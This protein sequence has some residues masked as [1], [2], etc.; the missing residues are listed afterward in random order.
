MR[1]FAAASGLDDV[2]PEDHAFFTFIKKVVRHRFRQAGFRRFS[3]PVFEET[4]LYERSLGKEC[5]IFS[6]ELY[7]FIDRQGRS[8]SLRPEITTSLVRAFIQHELDKGPL[9]VEWYYI[10]HCFRYE[11]PTSRTKRQ[12]WQF[13]AEILGESD[14]AIDAQIIFLGHQI[15]QDLGLRPHSELKIN[16]LGSPEDRQNFFEALENFYRGKERYLQPSSQE[17]LEQRRYLELLNPLDEDEKVLADMAPKLENYLGASAVESMEE[18]TKYLDTFDIEYVVD[19]RLVRSLNYYNGLI[20]EFHAQN[21]AEKLLVGGRYDGLMERLGGKDLGGCGFAAGL[22]RIM[23]RMKKHHKAVPQ[24]DELQVFLAATGPIAK[25]KALPYLVTLRQKGYH[26][27]GVLGKTSITEQLK[28]AQSFGV[29]YTI[30]MG[31]K[32]AKEHKLIIRD[33][34]T[35]KQTWIPDTELLEHLKK[36]LPGAPD[37]LEGTLE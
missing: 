36:L 35:G 20:F 7:S 34:A 25:K 4:D 29:P 23:A 9:P 12:F 15:L 14:S 22:E 18:L 16:T 2:F 1:K 33:M 10:E 37:L 30:L 24:K 3:P 31:D 26:A 6:R 19:P 11:R 21:T 28:R 17:K 27:I 5:D 8:Y 32:E 13:G